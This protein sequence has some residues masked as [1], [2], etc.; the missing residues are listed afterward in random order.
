M[1][2]RANCDRREEEFIVL[3]GNGNDDVPDRDLP[4]RWACPECG[5]EHFVTWQRPPEA[6]IDQADLRIVPDDLRE[7]GIVIAKVCG[8]GMTLEDMSGA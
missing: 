5:H 6:V 7:L 8:E 1:I 3:I 4:C 2:V